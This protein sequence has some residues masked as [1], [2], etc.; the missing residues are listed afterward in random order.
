MGNDRVAYCTILD[1]LPS[2]SSSSSGSGSSS[3]SILR[4]PALV[5]NSP[6]ARGPS[7]PLVGEGN[8]TARG[9]PT[10]AEAHVVAS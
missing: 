10:E 7:L 1:S 5:S 2:E 8:E 3:K 4:S 6:T 9:T